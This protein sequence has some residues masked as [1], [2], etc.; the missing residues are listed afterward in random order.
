M[1]HLTADVTARCAIPDVER[2]LAKGEFFFV[3]QPK[4]RLNENRISGFESLL[5]WRHPS[6]GVFTPDS[7]IDAQDAGHLSFSTG[8][9]SIR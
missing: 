2:G 6:R 5:R 4:L 3:Y 8:L 1:K 9:R 7:V